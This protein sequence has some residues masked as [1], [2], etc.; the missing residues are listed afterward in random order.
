MISS[1]I[2]KRAVRTGWAGTSQDHIDTDALLKTVSLL[3][4]DVVGGVR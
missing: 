4:S 3:K 1:M 2:A